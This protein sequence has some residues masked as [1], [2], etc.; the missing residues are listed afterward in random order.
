[1]GLWVVELANCLAFKIV[2][3]LYVLFRSSKSAF[4]LS[5][6]PKAPC[7]R[8]PILAMTMSEQTQHC[9]FG[10]TKTFFSRSSKSAFCLST[11]LKAPCRRFP[12][13]AMTMSE[14]ARHC[15]FGLT[16]TFFDLSSM[17]RVIELGNSELKNS[18]T[19]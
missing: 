8:F 10:L 9:S 15:S 13:L 1:M 11:S 19:D 18:L 2:L 3:N 5:T 6:S 12:I 17:A 14:Q 7:W 16:K 4:C